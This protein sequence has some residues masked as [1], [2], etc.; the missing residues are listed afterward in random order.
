MPEDKIHNRIHTKWA[1]AWNQ[2]GVDALDDLLH[3]DYRRIDNVGNRQNRSEFK[4]SITAVRSAFPDLHTVID[5]L[6]IE[7]D[8][9]AIRWH[10]VGSHRHSFFGVPATERHVA[11]SGATFSHFE[12]D[13]IVEEFVTWDPSALLSAL[14]ILAVGVDR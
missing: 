5:D 12:G 14:G 10:S 7:G 13:H 1:C 8:R 2:G 3:H 9:A 6:V 11:V 4:S